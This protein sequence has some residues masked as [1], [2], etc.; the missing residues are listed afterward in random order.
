MTKSSSRLK[1]IETAVAA[2]APATRLRHKHLLGIAAGLQ[3]TQGFLQFLI[4]QLLCFLAISFYRFNRIQCALLTQ[5][6]STP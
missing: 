2:P 4:A 5:N 6:S 1:E 3:T